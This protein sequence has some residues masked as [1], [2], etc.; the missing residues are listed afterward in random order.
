MRKGRGLWCGLG[1]PRICPFMP[2]RIEDTR[3]CLNFQLRRT[4]RQVGRYYDDALR[5]LSLRVSQ[6][7]VLAVLAQTGPLP[8]SEIANILGMERSALARNLKPLQRRGL[9]A[10]APGK[11]RRVRLAALKLAGRRKLEAALPHWSKAQER[12]VARMGR[13]GAG[14]LADSLARLRSALGEGS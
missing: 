6:F 5:P 4:A 3:G 7:N 13:G 9:L 1:N 11:D 2:A 10:V 8:V 12:L 14:R